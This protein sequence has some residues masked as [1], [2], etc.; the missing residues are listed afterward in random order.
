MEVFHMSASIGTVR[1]VLLST[2]VVALFCCAGA[3]SAAN[4]AQKEIK[5]AAMHSEFAAKG[6]NAGEAHL[7]LHH[8]INCLVGSDG[9]GFD[10]K[11]GDPCKGMGNGALNDFQG[12]A[13]TKAKL[14]QALALAKVG[15]QIE[16]TKPATTTAMAVHELLIEAGKM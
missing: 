9:D 13:Q 1:R 7:H 8:T 11:A 2:T 16:D 3:A 6:K 14:E 15:V 4:D 12:S 10:A 5:T